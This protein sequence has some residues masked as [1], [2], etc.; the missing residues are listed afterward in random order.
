M[1]AY[2]YI[3]SYFFKLV[4]YF[5]FLLT[6]A[7]TG[8]ALAPVVES[9]WRARA[10]A[11]AFYMVQKGDTL[12]SIAFRYDLDY[13][14][15]AVLNRLAAPYRLQVGQR[16]YIRNNNRQ[17]IVGSVKIASSTKTFSPKIVHAQPKKLSSSSLSL[18]LS[19]SQKVQVLPASS[20]AWPVKGKLISHFSPQNGKKGI[21]IAGYKGAKISAAK[22]GVVAY[23]GSGLNG[24]GNLIIIK[25]D[26][27]FLTAY[28]NNARNFVHEGQSVKAGQM[29]AQMGMIDG[30]DWGLHFEIRRNGQPINPV[31]VLP[32]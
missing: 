21:N 22:S 25:H 1:S 11:P 10:S 32:R 14:Q 23:A 17:N 8:G 13:R 31:N 24:Y 15:L 29:I 12:Y 9:S 16:L 7:C 28:A 30:H 19:A 26:D 4:V 6:V 2:L 18:G 3:L 5:L 20:W 27:H